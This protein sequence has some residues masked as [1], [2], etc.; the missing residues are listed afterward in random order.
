MHVT[1]IYKLPLA[2]VVRE[3]EPNPDNFSVCDNFMLFHSVKLRF[4]GPFF[5]FQ[6]VKYTHY[7]PHVCVGQMYIPRKQ[8]I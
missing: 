5:S 4:I 6:I 7:K 8:Q 2:H 3:L 1:T